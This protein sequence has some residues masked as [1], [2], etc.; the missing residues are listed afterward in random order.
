MKRLIFFFGL[1][2]LVYG[3]CFADVDTMD[4]TAIT[5]TTDFDGVSFNIASINGQTIAGGDDYS[6]IVFWVGFEGSWDGTTYTIGSDDYSDGDTTGTKNSAWVVDT[7]S[8]KVGSY[9]GHSK[10]S[11]DYII[12]SVSSGDIMSLN[13]SCR[14]GFYFQVNTAWAASEELFYAEYDSNNFVRIATA[15]SGE[16][17]VALRSSGAYDVSTDT[18]G[19]SLSHT[20][21]YFCELIFDQASNGFTL[22]IDGANSS[23]ASDAYDALPNDVITIEFGMSGVG[24][25]TVYQDQWMVSDDITRNLNALKD[26]TTSPR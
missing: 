14:I 5:T 12:F 20:T 7:T 11:S 18:S 22:K 21:W 17:N 13:D 23:I 24:T 4:G 8:K 9:G 10:G 6:D 25:N 16:I 1:F 26:L 19:L 3:Y 15:A 2:L